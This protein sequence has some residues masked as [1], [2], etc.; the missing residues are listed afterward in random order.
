[1]ANT[2]FDRLLRE[3]GEVQDELIALPSDAFAERYELRGRQDE[4]RERIARFRVDLDVD[5]STED[6]LR[7]LAGQRARLARLEAERIDLVAQS[8]GGSGS[9]SG[10][11]GWGA[12]VLN[13]QIEAAGGAKEIKGR[14][15]RIKGIL[16]DRGVEIPNAS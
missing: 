11:D 9:G 14:I 13:Q 8:G 1:M 4:L 2:D 3:L 7:E 6:L 15:G 12:V 16:I 5:R 10:S